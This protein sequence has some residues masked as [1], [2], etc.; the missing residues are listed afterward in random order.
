V[1]VSVRW[2]G[3]GSGSAGNLFTGFITLEKFGF[4]SYEK[5]GS[6]TVN[7]L[8]AP[9]PPGCGP[10]CRY[11]NLNSLTIF[12]VQLRIMSLT[13]TISDETAAGRITNT[14]NLELREALVTVAEII[15]QRVRAEVEKYN[16]EKGTV[17][18]GLVQPTGSDATVNGFQ[19]KNFMPVDAEEQ[20]AA[21]KNA[22]LKNGFFMLIDH[23]Q[24]G[25]LEQTFLLHPDSAISFVKLTPLVGG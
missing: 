3:Y 1:V 7:S 9:M 5:T 17:F 25:S 2:E 6:N 8:Q 14:L 15:E 13:V 21:A 4:L 12:P 10:L 22:F 18:H 23:H 16:L 19:Q 11:L 20:V 24:A